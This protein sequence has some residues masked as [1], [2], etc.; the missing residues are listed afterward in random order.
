MEPAIYPSTDLITHYASFIASPHTVARHNI[1]FVHWLGPELPDKS[2]QTTR[3]APS[4]RP[5]NLTET[6]IVVLDCSIERP[7]SKEMY[8]FDIHVMC[9]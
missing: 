1:A 4:L 5:G 2:E 3:S 7:Y 6:G 8:K 9:I